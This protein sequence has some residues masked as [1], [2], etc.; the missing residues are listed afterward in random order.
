MKLKLTYL[1]VAISLFPF[2]AIAQNGQEVLVE[3]ESMP[4][5]E[6]LQTKSSV[7]TAIELPFYDDFSYGTSYP[8]V[9]N[10]LPSSIFINTNYSINAP[11]VGVAT[12]DAINNQG[13]LHNTSTLAFLADSLT[14]QPINLNYLSTDSVYFSFMYQ[15]QGLGSQPSVRDSLILEFYNPTS[16]LWQRVWSASADFTYKKIKEKNHL[17]G[18]LKEVSAQQLK[19]S[20]FRVHFPIVSSQLLVNN[21]QFRF[22]NYASITSNTQI[23]SIRGNGDHWNID[24]VYINKDRSY[25][26][27]AFNDIAYI[28]PLKTLF[29][30]YET[31]PW[32]HFNEQAQQ[33]EL[34]YY[35]AF[36]VSYRNLGLITWNVTRFF[37]IK[38]QSNDNLYSLPSGGGSDNILGFT[39]TTV[40][41]QFLYTFSSQWSDSAHF[42]YT[43]YNE[44]DNDPARKHLRWNDTLRYEQKMTNYYA[45]D[46][47][48]AES[49]Y[50]I[51]GEGTQNGKVAVKFTNFKTDN[52]VGVYMY[53]N[54][55]VEYPNDDRYFKLAIWNDNNGKPGQLI[56]EQQGLRPLFPNELN[57][58]ALFKLNEP[59]QIEAGTFYIGYIQTSTDMLNHGFD[60]NRINN[61]KIFYNIS[62]SW[63][64]SQF[65]GSLMIRPVFGELTEAPTSIVTPITNKQ[66]EVTIYPNPASD[67]FKISTSEINDEITVQI[68][69]ISGQ[70]VAQQKYFNEEINVSQL[71]NGVYLVKVTLSAGFQKTQKL[72]I[73]R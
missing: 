20:F 23:P 46:D 9:A 4:A 36:T 53:F 11:T 47:G 72:I 64:N 21:F 2:L 1:A 58:F 55:I 52:L 39:D 34:N 40:T 18:T 50:G 25:A 41:R 65:Q 29:N 45:Y 30:N 16:Q 68:F 33:S 61:N 5:N 67:S 8:S 31:F 19:D 22:R 69:S 42:T 14:S 73:S 35:Q 32:K 54:R 26:N 56:Y 60:L 15:P 37:S 17:L 44:T 27:T 7:R 38:N 24:L 49:G 48:T 13:N 66:K 71:P 62:G 3:L 70:L 12:F 10:W 59:L 63:I 43:A 51:Y 28:K 57:R 6:L